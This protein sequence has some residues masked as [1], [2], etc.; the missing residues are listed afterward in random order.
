MVF[1]SALTAAGR[2][3]WQATAHV[4]RSSSPSSRRRL[5]DR[6]GRH[7]PVCSN[8]CI[9]V[10]LRFHSSKR[11]SVADRLQSMHAFSL[12]TFPLKILSPWNVQLSKQVVRLGTYTVQENAKVVLKKFLK[13][14]YMAVFR[15]FPKQCDCPV[16]QS[17][18]RKCNTWERAEH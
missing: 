8:S 16:D 18:H 4:S 3:S 9:N 10:S 13:N 14:R 1:T 2:Y 17:E 5:V 11:S 15:F 12:F 7:A 6:G